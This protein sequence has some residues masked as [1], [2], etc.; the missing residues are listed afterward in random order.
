MPE[1][2]GRQVDVAA[3]EADDDQS[4]R[5]LWEGSG[6]RCCVLSSFIG[7]GDSESTQ[8]SDDSQA[9]NRCSCSCQ[10]RNHSCHSSP[11]SRSYRTTHSPR[12]C[13]CHRDCRFLWFIHL[14]VFSCLFIS[15][16]IAFLSLTRLSCLVLPLLIPKTLIA[17]PLP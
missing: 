1:R 15:L 8:E 6:H 12:C 2:V 3:T 10:R 16:I 13:H 4:V 9:S 17:L 11:S 14:I 5:G 7:R